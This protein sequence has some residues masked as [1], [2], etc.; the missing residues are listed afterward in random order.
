MCNA[1]CQIWLEAS[2]Y[3]PMSRIT[4]T[5]LASLLTILAS[6]AHGQTQSIDELMRELPTEP[7]LMDEQV[8]PPRNSPDV[9]PDEP[10]A[11]PDIAPLIDPEEDELVIEPIE[12]QINQ[13]PEFTP[14]PKP[15]YSQLTEAQERQARLDKL[16]ERLKA[17]LLD[18]RQYF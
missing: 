6:P 3:L 1:S 4:F 10:P 7:P 2:L 17:C 5:L 12:P 8:T 16:F 13:T 18:I 15:D 11:V 14:S 9:V